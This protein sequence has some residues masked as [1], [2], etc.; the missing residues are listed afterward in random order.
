MLLGNP[1]LACNIPFL[2]GFFKSAEN[3]INGSN[4]YPV[5]F[6]LLARTCAKAQKTVI[7][8]KLFQT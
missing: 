5:Q 1:A 6:P 2:A 7:E 8:T 4:H 3:A